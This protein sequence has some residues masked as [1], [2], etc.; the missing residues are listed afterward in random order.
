MKRLLNVTCIVWIIIS[1][2]C[3]TTEKKIA[4]ND[5]PNILWIV[6]E[7]NSPWLG[8]Y[9]DTIAT[10][11]HLDRFAS[12]GILFT[13]AY[14]NAPVCAPSR[15]TLITGMYSPALGTQHMRSTYQ[16]PDSIQFYPRYLKQVGYYT[17]NNVKK[18]YNTQD[19]PEIWNE[20]SKTASYK[21]RKEGQPF[22]HIQNLMTSHES[23][24]HRDS[25]PKNH[26]AND[27]ILHPFHPDTPAMRND[28]AVYYDRLQDLDTEIGKILTQLEEEDLAENTIVFYYSDHGGPIAGTKR[29]ATQQGLHVP[30]LIRIPEK[31]KHLTSYKPGDKVHRPV[32]FIDFPPTLLE[33]VG[34]AIPDQFQGTPFL[35]SK[36][37]NPLVF[38]FAGRMDEHMNMVRTVTDG[39]YRY[40]RNYM[41]NIPYGGYLQTLWKS[42]GMQ[43]WHQAYRNQKTNVAQSAF[44]EARAFEELYDIK[45]DPFQLKNL[46]NDTLASQV[47]TKLSK[48]LIN[49]QIQNRD[50]GFIPEAMLQEIEHDNLIYTYIHSEAYPL[51]HVLNLIEENYKK[52]T[53]D[54]DELL[55][56]FK[57]NH[58]IINFWIAQILSTQ[59]NL[60]VKA[61]ATLKKMLYG[62]KPFTGIVMAKALYNNDDKKYAFEYLLTTL[63]SEDLMIRV[64][65]LNALSQM[66]NIPNVFNPKLN[67]LAAET[68]GRKRPYDTR[69][70]I[71]L[72]NSLEK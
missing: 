16:I 48:A 44:F 15:N 21:N 51:E 57:H 71:H 45:K 52:D 69:L 10:T 63:D 42:K 41:P 29:Y 6:S 24:L 12:Q 7:D 22:F 32:G 67:E 61:V 8:C 4:L 70:A 14:S 9:G 62:V 38:G 26:K 36:D 33:L 19:R 59:K 2:S 55:T 5:R 39:N 3:N 35:N 64:Q 68:Q 20:S 18:D 56:N 47:K 43:S 37:E 31:F 66:E 23:R 49:W 72:L 40:T 53:I 54:T 46:A 50:A 1:T 34:L 65:A 13:N 58:P 60:N 28:Y 25:I 11:P 30:L 17:T 27:V